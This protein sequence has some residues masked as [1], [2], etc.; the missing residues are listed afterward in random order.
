[1]KM[2]L[3]SM[4]FD[5][6]SYDTKNQATRPV[7]FY[8]ENCRK[9]LELDNQMVLFCDS[10]TRPI[11]ETIRGSR[12]TTYV[13]R[14]LMDY[15]YLKMLL[16]MVESARKNKPHYND[17]NRATSLYFLLMLMKV[18]AVAQAKTLHTANTYMWIDM[19][20]SHMSHGFPDALLRIIDAPRPKISACCVHYRT[21]GELYPVESFLQ[22]GGPTAYAASM[23]TVEHAY[24]DRLY[25]A[26]FSVLYDQVSNG[27]G[28][29]DEQCLV[30]VIDRHPEWFSVYFG[31]YNSC[32]TNYHKIVESVESIKKFVIPG[33]IADKRFDLLSNI[34]RYG[35]DS[36]A[37]AV[38]WHPES[39]AAK[40]ILDNFDEFIALG[41]D[42]HLGWGSY[43]FD[44]QT[45]RYHRDTLKKQEA[46]VR[47]GAV[48]RHV[49][50]IGV[51][52]GHSLLL[53]LISNPTLKITC[54]DN[55]AKFAPRA[56]AY[57]NGR[58]GNRITFHLGNAADILPSLPQRTYDCI[59]ID[60]DHTDDAVR[61]QFEL[62]KQLAT[63]RAFFV[64]DDYEAVKPVIDNLIATHVLDQLELPGCIWTNIVTQLCE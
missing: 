58:F 42:F 19:G 54:I 30:Y 45:Y 33:L 25:T 31:D 63:P 64:F 55:D 11:I 22:Y 47:V 56:V 43:M 3:V 13:E 51:Y 29:S 21:K 16:P 49:L 48:S 17:S 62:S 18:Y 61:Q 57:L 6:R 41:P 26:M 10:T 9:T 5:L 34:D 4:F 27:L 35:K 52:L 14:S 32:L 8:I 39:C 7:S 46:L 36:I 24:V 40:L 1:M 44:G 38:R 23:F 15:D 20:I 12:P 60:A 59:H 53:L 37:E 28:H 2:I 50:E